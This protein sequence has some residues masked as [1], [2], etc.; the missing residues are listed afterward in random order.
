M[1][2]LGE[3]EALEAVADKEAAETAAHVALMKEANLAVR[4]LLLL[5]IWLSNA[6]TSYPVHVS[7]H[8]LLRILIA[9]VC[10]SALHVTL[11]FCILHRV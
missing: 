2:E 1:I 7:M 8:M 5:H 3:K 10:A 4:L 6:H 9:A 11:L